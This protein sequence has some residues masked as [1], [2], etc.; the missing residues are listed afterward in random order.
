MSLHDYSEDALVEQPAIE[1]FKELGWDA[2]NCMPEGQLGPQPE[3][4]GRETLSEVVLVSRLRPALEWLN[5]HLPPPAIQ[6]AID[7]LTRDLGR[8]SPARANQTM[9][10]LIKNGV[11]VPYQG[12]DGE[13]RV[14]IVQVIDWQNRENNDY[15]LTSQ[16]WIT[17]ELYT[18]RPDLIGFV[19]GLP[20]VFIDVNDHHQ[21][22]WL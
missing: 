22:W 7:E 19:N 9:Y 8:L 5:P 14:D 21:R 17:G 18:K 13:E 6:A 2:I 3:L 12:D 10:S 4:S 20:L 15:L 1:R 11:R 16:L